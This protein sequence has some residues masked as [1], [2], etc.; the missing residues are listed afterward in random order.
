[1]S[2]KKIER[3][4]VVGSGEMGA[5]IGIEFARFGYPVAL[6]DLTEEILKKSIER[7][8]VSLDLM[9]SRT[10]F[11]LLPRSSF[12]FSWPMMLTTRLSVVGDISSNTCKMVMPASYRLARLAA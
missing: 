10:S 1:M 6:Y 12:H 8:C 5:G 9:V 3:V 2:D 11:S 7:A 4:A